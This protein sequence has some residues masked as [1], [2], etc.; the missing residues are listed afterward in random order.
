MPRKKRDANR[1]ILR[2]DIQ[3]LPRAQFWASNAAY[4]KTIRAASS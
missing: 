4:S 2:K 3:R 1:A